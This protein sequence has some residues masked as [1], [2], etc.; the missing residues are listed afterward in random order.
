[1]P[2]P[3]WWIGALTAGLFLAVVFTLFGFALRLLAWTAG[4]MRQSMLPGVVAGFRGWAGTGGPG[5]GARARVGLAP[6]G[7]G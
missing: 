3:F 7:G 5:G 2:F 4:E 1:M 6:D